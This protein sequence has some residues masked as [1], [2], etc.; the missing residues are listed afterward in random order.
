MELASKADCLKSFIDLKAAGGPQRPNGVAMKKL[1]LLVLVLGLA[2]LAICSRTEV[3]AVRNLT[4][5]H[6]DLSQVKDGVFSGEYAY[7]GF[8]YQVKVT[9]AA[10]NITDVTQIQNR[11][12]KQAKMAAGVV[13][14]V[15]DQQKND[16]D[17]VSGAM[18][19]SKALLKAI[20]NALS[21]GL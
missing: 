21:A 3:Q 19:T 13:A 4:I 14:R 12:T 15:L 16:V 8:T 7:A 9:L 17:A 11:T 20:E 10:H 1:G 6:I 18:T 2:V 5:N